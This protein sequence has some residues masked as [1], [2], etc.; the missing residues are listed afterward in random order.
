MTNQLESGFGDPCIEGI[1]FHAHISLLS[2]RQQE[3]MA[4]GRGG[5]RHRVAGMSS[6][7]GVG[8]ETTD[9]ARGAPSV[10]HERPHRKN[11]L[12]EINGRHNHRPC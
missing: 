5:M 8:K 12:G 2:S 7:M 10:Q 4:F 3:T 9:F 1:F 11:K 6:H